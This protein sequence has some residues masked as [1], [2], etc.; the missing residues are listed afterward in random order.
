MEVENFKNIGET[1]EGSGETT[2]QNQSNNFEDLNNRR[3]NIFRQIQTLSNEIFEKNETGK[4][5]KE[6]WDSEES[7][8]LK[9]ICL[10]IHEDDLLIIENWLKSSRTQ[11]YIVMI[12]IAYSGIKETKELLLEAENEEE[13]EQEQ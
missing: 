8:R 4:Q 7:S 13:Q 6:I 12:I 5:L 11:S 1:L 3:L 2:L 9:R 10:Q